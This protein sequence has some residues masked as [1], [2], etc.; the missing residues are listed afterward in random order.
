MCLPPDGHAGGGPPEPE[1]E[2]EAEDEVDQGCL[3]RAPNGIHRETS[4]HQT[5]VG[6]MHAF[7]SLLFP[8]HTH[9]QE[10]KQ[11]NYTDVNLLIFFSKSQLN[12]S[13]RQFNSICLLDAIQA[14]AEVATRCLAGGR[15]RG[16]FGRVR[17]GKERAV[18]ASLVRDWHD[19][20]PPGPMAQ[21]ARRAAKKKN[22]KTNTRVMHA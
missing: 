20:L 5:Q 8:A 3:R 12:Q 15:V 22:S 1:G 9:K 21:K 2:E 18:C 10:S 17:E 6:L 13:K 16:S 7:A 11:I 14:Q 19:K 4:Q